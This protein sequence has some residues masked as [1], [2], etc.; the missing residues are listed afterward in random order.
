MGV[1]SDHNPVVFYF[2]VL[3]T[4]TINDALA[5]KTNKMRSFIFNNALSTVTENFSNAKIMMQI[6]NKVLYRHTTPEQ[7]NRIKIPVKL[8]WGRRDELFPLS[9]GHYLQKHI[10]KSTL[11]ELD[12]NHDWW[13]IHPQEGVKKV[14]EFIS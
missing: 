11:E 6:T 3:V 14:K 9:N 7:L 12:G 13:T 10:A 1:A 5:L 4:K 8:L 2:N